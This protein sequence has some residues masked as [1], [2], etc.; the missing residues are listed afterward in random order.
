MNK[1]LCTIVFILSFLPINAQ[2]QNT[3]VEIQSLIHRVDSLEH[4]LSY[5]RTDYELNRVSTQLSMFSNEVYNR[6]IAILLDVYYGNLNKR[7]WDSYQQ[8]YE[9]CLRK[10]E[11]YPKLIEKVKSFCAL[12]LKLSLYSDTEKNAL[13]T[14]SNVIDAAYDTLESSMNLLKNTI[15]LYKK[16]M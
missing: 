15:D 11:V 9:T 3:Q 5:L 8:Y 6:S 16:A 7:I 4:E 10:M 1:F 14:S 12:K 2:S 13:M